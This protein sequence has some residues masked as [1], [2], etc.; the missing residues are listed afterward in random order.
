VGQEWRTQLRAGVVIALGVLLALAATLGPPPSPGGDPGGSLTV[1]LPDTVRAIAL[2]LLGLSA[3]LLLAL[4]RPRKPT[5]DDPLLARVQPKRSAWTAVLSV[6]PVLLLLTLAWYVIWTS[7]SSEETHP[8]ERA[9]TAIVSLFD[10]LAQYRKPATS[11]P[12]FDTTIAL[13][14]LLF[15]LGLFALMVVVTLAERFEK[16]WAG[17]PAAAPAVLEAADARVDPRT[18]TDARLAIIRAWARF[19]EALAAARAPRAP[20]QTPAELMRATLARLTLPRPPVE[21]LTRLFELARFSD[22]PLATADRDVACDALDEITTALD[23]DTRA[24]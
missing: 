17:R 5:D 10:L 21:R 24:R 1:R 22:R 2:V 4:Q 6:L 14:V 16:W 19:E 20:W 13:V 3:L 8:I 11:V 12:L 18:V 15:A 9:V 7:W 23:E